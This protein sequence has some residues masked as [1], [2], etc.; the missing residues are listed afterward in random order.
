MNVNKLGLIKIT[1]DL[2]NI[3]LEQLAEGFSNLKIF[4]LNVYD[5][6]SHTGIR[7]YKCYSENFTEVKV[8]G[9][10]PQYNIKFGYK[11]GEL[12]SELQKC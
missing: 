12:T 1:H 9:N 4:A 5:D 7:V 10:I 11:D 2:L 6:K 3:G 8:G